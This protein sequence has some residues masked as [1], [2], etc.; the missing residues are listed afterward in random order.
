[1]KIIFAIL[2]KIRGFLRYVLRLCLYRRYD[3]E[4]HP[5]IKQSLKAYHKVKCISVAVKG[6]C[7]PDH[8]IYFWGAS[9]PLHCYVIHF[10][11]LAKELGLSVEDFR[12]AFGAEESVASPSQA[13]EWARDNL[14]WEK[15]ARGLVML[16]GRAVR[17]QRIY[18]DGDQYPI[19]KICTDGKFED[20]RQLKAVR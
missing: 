10:D 17:I 12:R 16:T 8:G 7:I 1:M 5:S 18:G 4:F 3:P 19:L 6:A 14:G 13:C 11:V 2:M 15:L 20:L 9:G